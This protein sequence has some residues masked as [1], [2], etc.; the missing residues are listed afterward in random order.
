LRARRFIPLP[1][2][3]VWHSLADFADARLFLHGNAV[4]I[5]ALLET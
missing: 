5:N 4:A 2:S 3:T 1:R